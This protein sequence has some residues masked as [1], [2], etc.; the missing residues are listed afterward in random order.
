MTKHKEKNKWLLL[1]TGLTVHHRL[2]DIVICG[3]LAGY[4]AV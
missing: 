2:L 3:L 4:M 1:L